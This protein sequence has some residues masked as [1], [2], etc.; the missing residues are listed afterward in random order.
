MSAF[1]GKADK[2]FN[3][4]HSWRVGTS[5]ARLNCPPHVLASILN[6]SPGTTQGITAIYNR[7]RYEDE[8]R[9]ALEAWARHAMALI[10]RREVDVIPFEVSYRGPYFDRDLAM[11]H[12]GRLYNRLRDLFAR[13]DA[14]GLPTHEMADRIAWERLE[15]VRGA[16]AQ[17]G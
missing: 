1:G 16:R 15:Q 7:Y 3:G 9:V 13:A 11:A 8:K 17:R 2:A 14:E 12:A 4:S 6:H 5:M 10:D